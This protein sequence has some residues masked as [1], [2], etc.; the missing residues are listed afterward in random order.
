MTSSQISPVAPWFKAQIET[1]LATLYL[2]SLDGCPAADQVGNTAKLWVRLLWDKPRNGWHEQADAPRLR[3]AFAS[4]A[5]TCKRWPSPAVFLEHLPK[6]DEP[7]T[8]MIGA[9]WGREREADALRCRDRWLADLGLNIAG[10]PVEP[11]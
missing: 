6:R 3:K 4:I 8:T 10:E 1:S 2:L 5:E 9:G 7:K 11:R